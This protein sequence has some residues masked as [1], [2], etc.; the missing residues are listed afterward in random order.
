MKFSVHTVSGALLRGGNVES[1]EVS[2]MQVIDPTQ[3]QS[4]V[5]NKDGSDLKAYELR[6]GSAAYRFARKNEPHLTLRHTPG[7]KNSCGNVTDDLI[8]SS[9][10]FATVGHCP[11]CPQ[12]RTFVS[13]MSMSTLCQKRTFHRESGIFQSRESLCIKTLSES[14]I[15][16]SVMPRMRC[17]RQWLAECYGASSPILRLP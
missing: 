7:R 14:R 15:T 13:P 11:L 6:R 17:M 1:R 9:V 4:P 12:K 10:A 5:T 3:R 16:L 2:P 8:T